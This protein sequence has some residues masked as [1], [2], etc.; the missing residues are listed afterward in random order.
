MKISKIFETRGELFFRNLEEKFT[1]KKLEEKN[2]VISLGGG[3]FMNE[4][5]QNKILLNHL[6]FWLKWDNKTLIKR[7]KDSKKRPVAFKATDQEL[8]DLIKKRSKSYSK[9]LYK[10]KC[11]NL[12]KSEIVTE[13]L[14]IYETN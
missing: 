3:A 12:K 14:N 9:A 8:N 11:D 7:I 13:I 5:I 6:S 1:L 2:I 4:N 10:I